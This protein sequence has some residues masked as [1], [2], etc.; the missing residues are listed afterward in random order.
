MHFIPVKTQEHIELFKKVLSDHNSIMNIGLEENGLTDLFMELMM[1]GVTGKNQYIHTG[2]VVDDDGEPLGCST[3]KL[4]ERLK[5][6]VPKNGFISKIGRE[7]Y[8][9]VE[10]YIRAFEVGFK[11]A[12][13][14]GYYECFNILRTARHKTLEKRL[15]ESTFLKDYKIEVVET[16][17]PYGKSI[18]PLINMFL[19]GRSAGLSPKEIVVVRIYNPD[20]VKHD[21]PFRIPQQN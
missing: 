18:N 7:R 10:V 11:L 20:K 6:W 13:S 8:G 12:E 17:E 2:V 19:L 1:E 15:T 21:Y 9:T 14:F 3:I 16:I 5:C 4:G